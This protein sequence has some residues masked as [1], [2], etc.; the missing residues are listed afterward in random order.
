MKN[1]K[2]IQDLRDD[3]ERAYLMYEKLKEDSTYVEVQYELLV[4]EFKDELYRIRYESQ[5]ECYLDVEEIRK[6]IDKEFLKDVRDAYVEKHKNVKL[7][8]IKEEE[9]YEIDKEKEFENEEVENCDEQ[10]EV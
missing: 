4:D 10:S 8:E 7:K 3:V 9:K 5:D 2:S 1:E 6:E